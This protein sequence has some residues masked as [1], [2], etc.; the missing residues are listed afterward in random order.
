MVATIGLLFLGCGPNPGGGSC[1]VGWDQALIAYLFGSIGAGFIGGGLG[2]HMIARAKMHS[3]R[4]SAGPSLLG[5]ASGLVGG[6]VMILGLLFTCSDSLIV[7]GAAACGVG[8]LAALIAY[9]F[10]MVGAAL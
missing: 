10:G 5:I 7:P 8:L 4:P 9:S 6:T 2:K 1:S 3:A